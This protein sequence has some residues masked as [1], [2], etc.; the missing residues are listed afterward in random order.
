MTARLLAALLLSLM[1]T[2]LP[3]RA[4]DPP[5]ESAT[6]YLVRHAEKAT[7]PGGD[8]RLTPAGLRRA[9]RIA[10][11]LEHGG[12]V[13]IWSSDY[14]RTRQTA[15]PLSRRLGIEVGLYDPGEQEA[16]A[17]QLTA[18]GE[19]ALVVGHSNTIPAL[20]A[21]LCE[22][23]VRPIKEGEYGRLLVVT[24]GPEGNRLQEF[25]QREYFGEKKQP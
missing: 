17:G 18:A 16:F 9:E 13:S 19:S 24:L 1:I 8:P 10:A 3:A 25:Q 20:A 15:A 4:A 5:G 21:L 14:R 7:E 22:C 2:A 6:L 23:E 12:I 11:G